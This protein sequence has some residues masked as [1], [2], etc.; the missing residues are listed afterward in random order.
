[1]SIPANDILQAFA[2]LVAD[3]VVRR[4]GKPDTQVV[5]LTTKQAAEIACASPSFIRSAIAA[6]ELP[7]VRNGRV[8]RVMKSDVLE[9]LERRRG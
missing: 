2:A 5:L 6:G 4:L 8:L 3:E 7:A 1:M 9:W